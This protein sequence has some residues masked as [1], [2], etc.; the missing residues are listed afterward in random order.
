MYLV[1]KMNEI[2]DS[3]LILH[4]P[5]LLPLSISP[6]LLPSYPASKTTQQPTMNQIEENLSCMILT[7]SV[8]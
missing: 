7:L 2:W 5:C 4:A 1:W 8:F 3:K 6:L